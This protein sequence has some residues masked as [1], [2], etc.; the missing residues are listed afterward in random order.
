MLILIQSGSPVEDP[1]Q[2]DKELDLLVFDM[3]GLGYAAMYQPS[4]AKLSHKGMPTAALHGAMAS[5]FSKM[6]EFPTAMPHVLWD[7]RAAWRKA[8]L[9]EYKANRSDT[10]EKVEIRESYRKQVPY[11]Q[12][13]LMQLGIPQVRSG[14]AE[15]DDVGRSPPGR[16]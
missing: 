1:S 4:L 14:D 5:L 3:N 7:G 10:P 16:R 8:L 12:Q 15:A 9:P 2:Q 11:I 13:M 6:A